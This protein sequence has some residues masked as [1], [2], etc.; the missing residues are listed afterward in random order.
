MFYKL[1]LWVQSLAN[2]PKAKNYL[3]VISFAESS[4]FPIPP[5]VLLIP[6]ALENQ[7]KC[8][9]LAFWTTIFSVLG[10]VLGY[11]VGVF[12]LDFALRAIDF[13]NQR[14]NFEMVSDY[15]NE[16]GVLFIFIAGFSPVPYKIV[17]VASGLSGFNL[18]LFIL[19]SI[20]GRGGRFFLLA[21][22]I[23]RWGE[24]INELI[25]KYT[26]PIAYFCIFVL[27][28]YLLYRV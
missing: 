5:D 22:L 8:F 27:I 25:K 6:I 11:L 28:V 14:D 21:F 13:L 15:F 18:I 10:G 19:T 12:A 24:S 2:H 7:K 26:N 23:H 1:Y 4:F 17:A 16:Y 9:S 20:V 3:Y